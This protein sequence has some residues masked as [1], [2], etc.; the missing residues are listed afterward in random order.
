MDE[1]SSIYADFGGAENHWLAALLPSTITNIIS[2]N[3]PPS[4]H[5]EEGASSGVVHVTGSWFKIAWSVAKSPRVAE[6]C[7]VNIHSDDSKL[8]FSDCN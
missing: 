6:Q 7:D 2:H 4:I 1:N 8:S 3:G 5:G